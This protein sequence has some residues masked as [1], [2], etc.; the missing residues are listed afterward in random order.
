MAG[1]LYPPYID[2]T[3]PAFWLDY[4][5]SNSVI[6]G[7]S[8]TI[9]FSENPAVGSSISGYKLRLRTASTGSYLF[10][11]IYTNQEDIEAREVTFVLSATQAKKL[12]EG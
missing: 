10:E 11:P 3:L 2:G 4:D 9:P 5:A 12:K 1:K 7:A 6:T 8:I